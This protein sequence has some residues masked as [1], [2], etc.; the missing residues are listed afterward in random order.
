MVRLL[1]MNGSVTTA[2]SNP[3][4]VDVTRMLGE[5]PARC[6]FCH[7]SFSF[8]FEVVCVSCDRPMCPFC[9]V[10]ARLRHTCCPDCGPR[11]ERG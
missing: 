2:P 6:E 5:G 9:A 1:Q 8:E 7:G 10:R 3:R 11:E 4:I